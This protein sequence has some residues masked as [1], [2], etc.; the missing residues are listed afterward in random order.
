MTVYQKNSGAV[1]DEDNASSSQSCKVQTAEQLNYVFKA[2]LMTIF[3]NI[4]DL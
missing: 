2:Y 3:Y 4:S 1:S